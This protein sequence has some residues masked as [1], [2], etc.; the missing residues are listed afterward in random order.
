MSLGISESKLRAHETAEIAIGSADFDRYSKGFGVRPDW[1]KSGRGPGPKVDTAR[2]AKLKI[3]SGEIFRRDLPLP[4]T[5]AARLRL[6][7]R[8]A[9]FA[10]V[11]EAARR[12]G[13]TRSRLSAHETG[14]NR[15]SADHAKEYAASFHVQ[16][17]WLATGEGPSGYPPQIHGALEKLLALHDLTESEARQQL[18]SL[19][20]RDEAPAFSRHTR[21][22]KLRIP[23][24]TLKQNLTMLGEYNAA[25]LA[26]F[27]SGDPSSRKITPI[28]EWGFPEGYVKKVLNADPAYSFIVAMGNT[29]SYYNL[30]PGDRI[31]VDGRDREP[32]E[33][34]VFVVVR[35][36][37][38]HVVRAQD[39]RKA[40]T[41][42]PISQWC[43]LGRWVGR[44]GRP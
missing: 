32:H 28:F 15:I 4:Q 20:L 24:A 14:Q 30:A 9:G 44:I 11:S 17:H 43:I 21:A 10:S 8:L 23:K 41:D 5:A 35:G 3:R 13:W 42:R 2:A 29:A 27:V 31:L 16:P 33:E 6:A 25:D 18:P 26:E 36:G 7:R 19:K 40:Q 22:E 12:H 1:L 37:D 34:G 38:I 39:V